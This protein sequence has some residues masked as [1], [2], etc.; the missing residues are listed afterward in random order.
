M[1]NGPRY[2]STPEKPIYRVASKSRLLNWPSWE[3]VGSGRFDDPREERAYRVLYAGERRSA[4]LEALAKFR[5][6]LEGHAIS[7]LTR[8]WIND[9]RIARFLLSDRN[10]PSKWLDLRASQ[11]IQFLRSQ[12]APELIELGVTDFDHSTACGDNRSITQK[13]GLWAHQDGCQGILY[14]TRFTS[15][16]NCWAIFNL[17]SESQVQLTDI[18]INTISDDDSDF[19]AT[20]IEFSL[21]LPA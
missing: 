10:A 17:S 2:A 1:G 7:P 16:L 21:P 11:T 3:Y 19:A 4:F 14:T 13:I 9:R 5:P 8:S 15:E 12:L 20:R 18:E 6:D